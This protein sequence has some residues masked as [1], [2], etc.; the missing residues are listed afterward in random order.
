MDKVD[1]SLVVQGL[2]A[3]N[4]LLKCHPN[5]L[6]SVVPPGLPPMLA[7]LTHQER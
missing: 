4:V 6:V 1:K 7:T 3:A 5:L 2:L